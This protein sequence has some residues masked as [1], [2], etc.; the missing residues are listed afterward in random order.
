[1][2]GMYICKGGYDVVGKEIR[3]CVK[4]NHRQFMKTK[5][6]NS[7]ENGST[8]ESPPFTSHGFLFY[9]ELPSGYVAMV[10]D[11]PEMRHYLGSVLPRFSQ[12]E[13]SIDFIAINHCSTLYAKDCIH[14]ACIPAWDRPIRGFTANPRF[15]V[16]PRGMEKIINYVKERYNSMRMIVTEN[17]EHYLNELL[18]LNYRD[19]ADVG[20]YFVR[21][22]I[23]NFEWIDGYSV[24]YGLYYVDRQ[25][26]KRMPK[27]SAKWYKNFL[28]VDATSNSN[29]SNIF[30]R[31]N[32]MSTREM[33]S[34]GTEIVL[35][36]VGLWAMFVRPEVLRFA[37]EMMQVMAS[38][39]CQF[40]RG[41]HY[42][43]SPNSN[44]H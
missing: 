4:V 30:K 40:I 29:S 5:S 32:I 1:M 39:I 38:S 28:T 20:G 33:V 34:L 3:E 18:T 35:A 14:S 41:T 44:L 12:E 26:L 22:M 27:L 8:Q 7:H 19:G 24:R 37:E 10:F 36:V 17:A 2:E 9:T 16:V 31:K 21:S 15:F 6:E 23:D 43:S 42:S 25:T 11:P 13:I